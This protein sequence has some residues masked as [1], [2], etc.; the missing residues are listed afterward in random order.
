MKSEQRWQKV[1]LV[2]VT[3][4]KLWPVAAGPGGLA[5]AR[6]GPD[7]DPGPGPGPGRARPLPPSS[8]LEA[9]LPGRGELPPSQARARGSAAAAILAQ[10]GPTPGGG[11]EPGRSCGR[12]G[13]PPPRRPRRPSR[14]SDCARSHRAG[15]SPGGGAKSA[16]AGPAAGDGWGGGPAGAGLGEAEPGG[17]ARGAG[18]GGDGRG[19]LDGLRGRVRA[20]VER[21]PRGEA[22]R[23]R[24]WG[25]APACARA[26]TGFHA[27][28]LPTTPTRGFCTCG[29]WTRACAG[30]HLPRDTRIP[31]VVRSCAGRPGERVAVLRGPRVG[32]GTKAFLPWVSPPAVRGR[33]CSLSSHAWALPH[34]EYPQAPAPALSSDGD[35]MRVRASNSHCLH[36]PLPTL[37]LLP[38]LFADGA[39]S[40]QLPSGK[41]E[42]PASLPLGPG[43]LLP[44]GRG[45]GAFVTTQRPPGLLPGRK[46]PRLPH[47]QGK[48]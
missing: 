6:S 23:A 21:G 41:P 30:G 7:P 5:P 9:G 14:S 3:F 17:G 10:G 16:G 46:D 45:G 43:L 22:R 28:S 47:S 27:R 40:H 37:T 38:C 39:P 35:L 25:W 20:R 32:L 26:G 8:G 29:A 31:P 36:D 42:G 34:P 12:E 4:R 11:R 2:S 48:E 15:A 19:A 24:G 18:R 13:P 44:G 1:G 33:P